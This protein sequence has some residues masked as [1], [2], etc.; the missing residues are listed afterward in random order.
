MHDPIASN[1]IRRFLATRQTEAANSRFTPP[2]GIVNGVDSGDLPVECLNIWKYVVE[3]EGERFE[4]KNPKSWSATVQHWRN[5]CAKMGITLPKKYIEALGGEGGA[6]RWAGKT[7]EQ[8]EDWVKETI[9]SK[10][11]IDDVGKS[12]Y[13]WKLWIAHYEKKAAEAQ[14]LI[15]KHI[16]GLSEAKTDKGVAQRT[17]WLQGARKDLGE[18]VDQ[19]EK[20]RKALSA[21][22][23]QTK[24][25]AQS[26]VPTIEFEKEFQFMLL[27][28]LKEFDK[29][30]VLEAV[31]TAIQRVE[32]GIDIPAP[33]PTV[34]GQE[35]YKTAG[36][37]DALTKAWDFLE[38]KFNQFMDWMK[39][40]T[41]LTNRIEK[42]MNEAGA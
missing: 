21:L 22:E 26:K 24:R 2:L 31:N 35:G 29:K 10:Q 20:A 8:V 27:L 25:Y 15:D 37:M 41:G 42:M 3:Y 18:Q 14:E 34:E 33:Y 16:K 19:L 1:V 4:P 11:L 28:A 39:G 40:L 17:K 36:L 9:K 30:T 38:D 6:G 5:K 7:G 13:D 23:E 12:C 32:D